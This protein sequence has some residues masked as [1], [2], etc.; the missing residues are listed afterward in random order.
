MAQT[1]Q[2]PD[3]GM[4]TA[5]HQLEVE[6]LREEGPHLALAEELFPQLGRGRPLKTVAA[7]LRSLRN[8]WMPLALQRG[9]WACPL[10]ITP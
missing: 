4:V 3:L 6:R 2:M 8:C 10:D 7:P 5:V 9:G 1:E